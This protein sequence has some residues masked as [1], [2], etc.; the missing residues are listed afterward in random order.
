MATD[1]QVL[2]HKNE[3]SLHLK[4]FGEFDESSAKEVLRI[5]K[6]GSNR[7]PK[8]FIHTN[9]LNQIHPEAEK[10]FKENIDSMQAQ[11]I[12]LLFTGE[13]ANQLAP[14]RNNLC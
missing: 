5:I 7:T 11:S 2:V 8:I 13:K 1:F 12:P 3:S 14:N 4:L 10:V 6:E 9:C